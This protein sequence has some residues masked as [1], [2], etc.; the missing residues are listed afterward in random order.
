[1]TRFA[2]S[3]GSIRSFDRGSRKE[4]SSRPPFTTSSV[5][6]DER[7][8][9]DRDWVARQEFFAGRGSE[10]RSCSFLRGE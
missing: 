7:R 8:S 5:L 3:A 1:M 2:I 10:V 6:D 9:K 4:G